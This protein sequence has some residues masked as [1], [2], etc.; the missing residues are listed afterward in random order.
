MVQS[1]DIFHNEV[2][3]HCSLRGLSKILLETVVR[4]IALSLE[5]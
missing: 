2:R 5:L 1:L 3:S 4:F